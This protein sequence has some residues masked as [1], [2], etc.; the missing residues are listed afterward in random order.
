MPDSIARKARP[1]RSRRPGMISSAVSPAPLRRRKSSAS[2]R[3]DRADLGGDEERRE[4]LG[5]GS[6]LGGQGGGQIPFLLVGQGAR[7][8]L[9]G[10]AGVD[11]ADEDLGSVVEA[12]TPVAG[13]EGVEE[14][15]PDRLHG[16]LPRPAFADGPA[17]RADDVL[18]PVEEE[19]LLRPEVVE[20]GVHRDVGRPGD[21]GHRHVVEAALDEE[22]GGDVGDAP[23]RL[24]L[25][26]LPQAEPFLHAVIV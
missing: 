3:H 11:D 13:V 14:V 25:L 22:R 1:A 16:G 9:E 20:H 7:P 8:P 17:E 5:I 18:L 19:V 23:A 26:P 15:A 10:R 24:P 2:T 6:G 12:E 21:L 4:V